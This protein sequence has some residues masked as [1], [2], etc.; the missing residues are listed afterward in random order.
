[1][2]QAQR[3]SQQVAVRRLRHAP[4][5]LARKTQS[6]GLATSNE[7]YDAVIIGGGPGGYVAAIKAAQHGLKTACIEKRGSLGGTCL[8]V[9]CIPSK[10]MLNNSHIY[11][12]TKHDLAKRGIE[13]SD[14][15][16]NLPQMLKAKQDSVTALTKGVEHLFKQNKVDYIKG[17][18]SFVSPTK[19]SVQLNDGGSTEIDAKNI[20]IATGSEVAP[21]PGGAI[22]I[23]EEQIVS[24]TGALELK[25]VPE[26]MVVIGGGIIG[27]EMGSVWSRLGA[28][29][30]VVEFLG[31]IGGVGIDEEIAK[32]FQRILGKQGLKFM[33]NTK[34]LSAE[35]R[36][37]KVYVK[38]EAAKGGKEDT[39]EADVVLVSVGRRP[40]TEGLNLDKVGVEVDPKGRIVVDSQ[41]NTTAQGI[42][43]IGDATFGPMLAH[44]AEEEGIAAVELIKT[45]HG[46]VNYH[47]IPSVVY[48]HPE[49]AWVGKTEQELKAAGVQYKIGKFPF[50]AN[51]RA[52]TNVDSEGQVKFIVEKETD[53]VLGV[54]I[55]GPNAGEMIAE[56]VLAIEYGASAE[57]I[58]RTCHAHP[59]LSEAFKEAAMASYDKPIHF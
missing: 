5:Q 19:L 56:A 31:G 18:A 7:P 8:N 27:L 45:G 38:T 52:K 3:A 35:K 29:V 21:F 54:H 16:L 44:K 23:D 42:K 57:D 11:H 34:V 12:Q 13:V 33:L 59:T 14:V 30:T 22:Q 4:V 32:Q 28:Q 50:S 49:V 53:K 17:T 47:A 48:T 51:S 24:S 20:I 2:L 10:A 36:D 6:R 43:C 9:G 25:Q 41:F 15:S 46:H 40:V 37:G 26:K 39:L 55:I 1:M 58:A